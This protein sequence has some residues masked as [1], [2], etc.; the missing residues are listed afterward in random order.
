MEGFLEQIEKRYS[1][2]TRQGNPRL[3]DLTS[4]VSW[5]ID[6]AWCSL[7]GAVRRGLEIRKGEKRARFG[8]TL[9]T[10]AVNRTREWLESYF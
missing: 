9:L 2:P 6:T 1:V 10:R 4:D 5:P 8:K 3:L 7:A